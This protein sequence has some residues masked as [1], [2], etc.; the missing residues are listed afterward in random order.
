[1]ASRM[2]FVKRSKVV[3]AKHNSAC[4]SNRNGKFVEFTSMEEKGPE[5]LGYMKLIG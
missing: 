5:R 1:M 3:Y 4:N 2:G